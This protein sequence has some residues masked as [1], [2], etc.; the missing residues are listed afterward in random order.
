M[1]MQHESERITEVIELCRKQPA[2]TAAPSPQS[3]STSTPAPEK[4][5]SAHA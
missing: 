3:T 1:A 2:A 4:A 5:S